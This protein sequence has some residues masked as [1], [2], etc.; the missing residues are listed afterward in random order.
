MIRKN[1][2]FCKIF[3]FKISSKTL[4]N[5][6]MPLFQPARETCPVCKSYGNLEIH[7][8]YKRKL[9][10]FI[11]GKP[12]QH[13]ITILRCKCSSCNATHAILPDYIIPYSSYSLFF[14]LQVLKEYFFHLHTIDKL[15]ERFH[16]TPKQLYKWIKLWKTHK[17]RWLGFM[18]NLEVSNQDFLLSLTHKE[19][20]SS[21]TSDFVRT[22]SMS[23]LQSHAN[24]KYRTYCQEI[25]S[26]DYRFRLST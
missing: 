6:F 23:F 17:S 15:C 10:D 2:L 25:F 11:D 18:K 12:V 7:S 24:P 22:F 9:V 26:P 13:E 5:R 16:I 4:F 1:S 3:Q 14:V 21:F 8:Y 19:E 20:P